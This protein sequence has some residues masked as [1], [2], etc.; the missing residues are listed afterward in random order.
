MS[1][2]EVTFQEF[3]RVDRYSTLMDVVRNRMTNREFIS[4]YA[5]PKDT[6]R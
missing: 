3:N 2:A 1:T 5:V 6:S 4:D